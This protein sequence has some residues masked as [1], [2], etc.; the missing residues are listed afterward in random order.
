MDAL[1]REALR[2]YAME[3]ASYELIRHN[4]N[5]T[6][7]VDHD[8]NLY[9]LR[10][11]CP[12]EGFV[13][14]IVTEGIDASRLFQSEVD[15]LRY[16]AEN[17]FE[18]VQKPLSAVSGEYIAKLE[19]GSPVMMLTWVDGYP[20]PQKDR[21]NYAKDIATLACRIHLAAKGFTGERPHYDAALTDRMIHEIHNAAASSHI[22]ERDSAVCIRELRVI[23]ET[24]QW[25]DSH[26]EPSIIHAD[27][28]LTNILV[29]GKGLLPI[30]FSFAGYAHLAQ[31]AGM[32]LSNYT[33]DDSMKAILCGFESDGKHIKK[34]DAE[35]FLSYSVLLFICMQHGKCCREEWFG[36][37]MKRWCTTLFIH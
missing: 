30:D 1:I 3:K 28:G 14:S 25:L 35:L 18:D 23:R 29:T 32:L 24:Q 4:E 27:L 11:H 13:P 17:G 26:E 34:E 10:I 19:N 21:K 22:K 2:S 37:S 31:E 5:I 20:I 15:L 7:K 16:M 9:V 12:V 6:C 8:G 36:H 33:D